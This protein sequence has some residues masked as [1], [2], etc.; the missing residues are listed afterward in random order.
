MVLAAAAVAAPWI[1]PYPPAAIDLDHVLEGPSAAHWLGTDGLGR[2][3]LSRLIH[4]G[5]VSLGIG[6]LATAVALLIG[7]PLGALAGFYGGLLDRIVSRVIEAILCFPALLLALALLAMPS[8]A[9]AAL[10]PTLRVAL[11]LGLTGWIPV[12]RYLRGEFLRLR[13]SE[14]AWSARAAGSGELRILWRHLLPA[15]LTPVWVT[16]AFSV[17]AAILAEAALSFLGVGVAPPTAT[18]GLLLREGSTYLDSAWWLSLF[19]GVALFLA[20][21]ASNLVGESLRRR[22]DPRGGSRA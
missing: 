1:A 14:L 3:V 5:R 17:G 15:A 12:A 9:V 13:D 18:W 11:V 22:F 4:G 16:A 8:P 6:G 7:L 10:S 20:L 21:L 2:D 19:P